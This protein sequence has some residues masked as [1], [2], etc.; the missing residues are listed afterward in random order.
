MK[1]V[2]GTMTFSQQVDQATAQSMLDLY[3]ASGNFELDTAYD[4]C[5][6]GT[7][8]LLGALL[9]TDKRN[10]FYI[11]SKVNPWNEQGLQP[12]QVKK[13]MEAILQRLG[14]DRIDL[15]YLHSPDLE[16][17][18]E[19]TLEA[20]FEIYQQGKFKD[21]GLSN[22][23]SWQV[24]EVAEIC[25]KNGWMEPSVYQ[26]MYNALTRDVESELFPCLRNYGIRF[27]AYNPLAGGLL[28]GKYK[29]FDAFPDS[30]RFADRHGYQPRYWKQEYFKVLHKLSEACAEIGIKPTQAAISWLV[31]HSK[32]TP[33]NEDR[34]ILGVT[35]IE[36]LRENM[37]ACAQPPLDPVILDI[38]DQGWE[39]IKPNCFRYFRP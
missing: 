39:I 1:T 23:S 16:T 37:A 28:T 32:L 24:A 19:Q 20:C 3:E 34:I 29:S 33:E 30:G 8:E 27:Y 21:F 18:V 5:E 22:Y 2:L 7:E 14:S 11:A 10:K 31:N 13:Q 6:G 38:L 26:G 36:H 35:R 17:P 15:L 4:Y 12:V 25:R 9:P